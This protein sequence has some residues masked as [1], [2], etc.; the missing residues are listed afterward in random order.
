MW[1]LQ[2]E[3]LLLSYGTWYAFLDAPITNLYCYYND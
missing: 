2:H 3:V 1:G